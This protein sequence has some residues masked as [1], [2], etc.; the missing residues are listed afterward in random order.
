VPALDDRKRLA[1]EGPPFDGVGGRIERS[2]P[3]LR[4]RL[5]GR[6][7]AV[8][9]IETVSRRSSSRMTTT[10]PALPGQ[11]RIVESST[12]LPALVT[13]QSLGAVEL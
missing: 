3:V 1:V 6:G 9:A 13:R 5:F 7:G 10:S 8:A 4:G 11:T 2:E 12:P